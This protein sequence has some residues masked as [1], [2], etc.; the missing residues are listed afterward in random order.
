[1]V[2]RSTVECA[3]VNDGSI[4]WPCMLLQSIRILTFPSNARLEEDSF[5]LGRPMFGGELLVLGNVLPLSSSRTLGHNLHGG[6]LPPGK[7]H[8]WRSTLVKR[9]QKKKT[10]KE[11]PEWNMLNPAPTAIFFWRKQMWQQ[12]VSGWSKESTFTTCGWSSYQ[13]SQR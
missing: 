6:T 7:S 1:M 11:T 13:N 5:L 9:S 12:G 2:E 4:Y 3:M 10:G 8:I